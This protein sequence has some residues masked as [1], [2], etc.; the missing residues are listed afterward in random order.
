MEEKWFSVGVESVKEKLGVPDGGISADEAQRRSEYGNNELR[1][2]KKKSVFVRF[3]EQFKDVMVIIL[4]CA[5]IVTTVIAI[6]EKNYSDFIDVGIILAIVII[7]A[8]IGVVQES[9]AE[10]ALE[11]LKNMSKPYAKVRRG[12]EIVKVESATLVPGEICVLRTAGR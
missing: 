7:N 4:I 10:Q 6:V 11:A 12:G 2:E 9:K 3:L 5:A 8:I 1:G